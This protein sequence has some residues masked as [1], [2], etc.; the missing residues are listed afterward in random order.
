[1]K[2]PLCK[3][4]LVDDHEVVRRGLRQILNQSLD[5][6]V[7]AECDNGADALHWLKRNQCDV[8]ILDIAMPEMNGIEL[9][10]ELAAEKIRVSVLVMTAYPE[11]QYATGLINAGV[12]GYLNKESCTE[13]ILTA[14]RR[15]ARREMY[16]SKNVMA[17]LANQL[18][19]QTT[20]L[21]HEQLS[22]R[23]FQI[24]LSLA[25]ANTVTEIAAHLRLSTK[26][27]STYRTRILEKMNMHGNSE[28]SRYSIEHHLLG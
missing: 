25:S 27:I 13:E 15:V 9:L 18:E 2:K 8:M 24:F 5:M 4:L 19:A 22:K 21:P 14:V 10:N 11:E 23:E 3:I 7:I 16:F 20:R 26:T 6:Q 17:I 12:L 28:L 1:M